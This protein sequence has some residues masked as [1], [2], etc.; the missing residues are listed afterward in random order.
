MY[1]LTLMVSGCKS[2]VNGHELALQQLQ[3]GKIVIY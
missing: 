3:N 1:L 2:S